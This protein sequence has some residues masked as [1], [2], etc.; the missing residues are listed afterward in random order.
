MPTDT[1]PQSREWSSSFRLLLFNPWSW[2]LLSSFLLLALFS[3]HYIHDPD[4]GFHLKGGQWILQNHCFPSTDTY[5]YTV[6]DHDYINSQWLYQIVLYL[7]YL[8]GNYALLSIF[9]IVLIVTAFALLWARLRSTGASLWMSALLFAGSVVACEMR[10]QVRPEILSWILL[11]GM[12]WVLELKSEGKKDLLFLLPFLQVIWVNV[13]GLNILGWGLMA[14]Y[15]VS[16]Y[17]HQRQ[18][19]LKMLRFSGLAMAL[20]LVNPYF[21]RG[22]FFPFKLWESIHSELFQLHIAEFISPWS[23]SS[24]RTMLDVQL[25]AYKLF[26]F[27]LIFLFLATFKRRKIH[28]FFLAGLFFYLSATAVRNIPLF[29]LTCLPMLAA[30]WKDLEWV[31]SRKFQETFLSSAWSSWILTALLLGLS[32]RVVTNAYYVDDRRFE[33]FGLGINE[34]MQPVHAT[35]FLVQNHLDGRILNSLNSGGWLDWK[36]PQKVFIDGRLEV[37][38]EKLF[39]EYIASLNAGGVLPLA[40][41]YSAD[42]LLF[43]PSIT[44]RWISDLHTS[45]QWRPVYLDG[46]DAIYLRNGY[47]P[48]VPALNPLRFMAENNIPADILNRAAELLRLPDPPAWH[49]F[50]EGF[51]APQI[52]PNGF[53]VIGN[54][55]LLDDHNETAEAFFLESVRLTGGKYYDLYSHLGVL[56]YLLGRYSEA[57]LCV[58]RVLKKDPSHSSARRI[59]ERLPPN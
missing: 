38:G 3:A 50:L 55:F 12:L 37:M 51:Y 42:I 43:N 22:V 26:S 32:L 45:G 29:I 44:P 13:E 16:S 5:T 59:L 36:G 28:E 54:F 25:W 34:E 4:L 49:T 23:H 53:P 31:W 17:F 6:P 27:L 21:F 41:K 56:Y 24:L 19:D 46:N 48:Q 57:R 18:F 8:A 40:D 1:S 30:C 58:E 2:T 11:G 14:A 9:N 52:Y 10:L 39:S 7:L 20:N 35:D 33:R 15:L 47:A